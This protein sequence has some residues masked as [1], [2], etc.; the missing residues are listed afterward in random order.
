VVGLEC[1]VE[2]DYGGMLWREEGREGDRMAVNSLG[3]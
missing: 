2:A 3:Q 1:I